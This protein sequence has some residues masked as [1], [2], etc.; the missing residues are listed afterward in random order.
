[1]SQSSTNTSWYLLHC[2]P[3]QEGRAEEHLVNQ[4]YVCFLPRLGKERLHRGLRQTVSVPLFP[5][6]L[7]VHLDHQKDNWN[8][9]HSTR[10]VNRLVSF[11][12]QPQTVP[13]GLIA[14]L[15]DRVAQAP[16]VIAL[17]AGDK[18]RVTEGAFMDVE[19]IFDTWDDEDRVIILLDMMQRRHRV[20][21]PLKCI[22]KQLTA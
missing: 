5:G 22:Q 6:Y 7:F 13:E 8:P 1:M 21:L 20:V 16:K 12:G 10:G 4:G 3:Q 2:K 18:I 14:A 19:A 11:G 15:Q 9:I 17:Q